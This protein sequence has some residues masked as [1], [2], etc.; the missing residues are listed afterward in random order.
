MVFFVYQDF[1]PRRELRRNGW[2][3]PPIKF[4]GDDVGKPWSRAENLKI[5]IP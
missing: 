1:G 3:S 2:R 4:G 5:V